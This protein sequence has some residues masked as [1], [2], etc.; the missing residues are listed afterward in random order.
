MNKAGLSVLVLAAAFLLAAVSP[1]PGAAPSSP[2]KTGPAGLPQSNPSEADLARWEKQLTLPPHVAARLDW[3][4]RSFV[5][6]GYQKLESLARAKASAIA[7]GKDFATLEKETALDRI[8]S[9]AGISGMD[10]SEAAFLVLAMATKDMDG[11]L[12]MIMAEIKATNA[13]KQKLR[14]QIKDL[15]KWI[16]EV[17]G[18]A[19]DNPKSSDIN[20]TKVS[21]KP[22]ATAARIQPAK[23]PPIRS[24]SLQ[25]AS[26]PV[27]RLEY[28]KAP[29]I[30]PLPP[31]NSDVSVS[32][33]KSLLDGIKDQLDGL[34]EL[35][36]MTSLRLQMTM[37][38]RSKF[39]STLSQMMK[40]TSTTQD[41]L[42][43]NIK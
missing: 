17:M 5:P 1:A 14:D 28:V 39:I 42:V 21:G 27:I 19:G 8:F 9:A 15:N 25:K 4:R 22:P 33:L 3:A 12:R 7:A 32:S 40:K 13:A 16:S 11:D 26:S 35:S 2:S 20:N 37:D 36:E 31:R 30:R 38:R 43:Q 41:I 10:A 18:K 29:T 24:A 34:N 23:V 6:S